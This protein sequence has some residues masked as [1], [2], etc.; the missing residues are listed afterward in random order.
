M[1]RCKRDSERGAAL[2]TVLVMLSVMA[3]LAIVATE[4]AN[5]GLRRTANQ[6]QL[7]QAR[8]YAMGAESFAAV[9]LAELAR[10]QARVDQSEWQ[11]RVFT[12]ALDEGEM[13][14]ILKDGANC[15][16]LNALVEDVGDER[17][18]PSARG[19]VQFARLL[20]LLRIPSGEGGGL[21]VPLTDWIDSDEEP[22]PGGA[23]DLSYGDE[24]APYRAGNG[25]IADISEVRGVRGFNDEIVARLAP[26]VCVR[27]FADLVRLNPNTLTDAQ[28]P[29]LS[30]VIG[31][32]L[33]VSAARQLI[34]SRPFGGWESLD[35][36]FAQPA[37]ASI[38]LDELTRAQFVLTSRYFVIAVRA[39]HRDVRESELALL[40]MQGGARVV[41]R[42]FGAASAEN[43]L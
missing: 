1:K 36:F 22:G 12:F 41:R 30:T 7:T 3:V 38:E 34:A 11:G 5:M 32:D 28:A 27:P 8:L 29:L 21:T 4:A 13:S 31:P 24:R 16:N 43:L 10:S 14:V 42:V 9:K 40:D 15:F 39:S 2:I 33:P 19:G 35:D 23:E 17:Y 6:T 18:V 25:L 20:D 37:L 26:Y